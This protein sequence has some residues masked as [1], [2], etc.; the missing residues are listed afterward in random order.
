MTTGASARPVAVVTGAARGIGAAVA[1]AL[2]E[3]GYDLVLGDAPAPDIIVGLR[4][5]L[6]TPEDL[7]ATAKQCRDTGAAVVVAPGDVRSPGDTARLVDAADPDRLVAAVAVAGVIGAEGPAWEQ[8]AADLDRDLSVNLHGVANLARAAIPRLLRAPRGRGRF[9]AVVSSAGER[10]L[11]RLASYVA[12]KHAALGY[13]RTLAADL[14]PHGVTANAVLPGSTDTTLLEHT[15]TV[16][17]LTHPTELARHQRLGR[18]L[19]PAEVAAAVVWLCSPAASAMTGTA[20][21]VDGGFTG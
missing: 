15:A 14:A 17:E 9:V 13:V 11:P 20:L 10:G 5:S 3:D 4:Y 18:L 19:E 2:A 8:T 12:A 21:R 1:L 16:Y 6:A 7:E